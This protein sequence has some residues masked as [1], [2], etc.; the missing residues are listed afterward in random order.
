MATY[1]LTWNPTRWE[2]DYLA[3]SAARVQLGEK[4]DDSWSTGS[5]QI[6]PGDRLFLLR[7]RVDPRGIMAAAAATSIA[8]VG[9]HYDAVRAAAG[10]TRTYVDLTWDVLLLPAEGRLLPRPRLDQSDLRGAHW[11]T[12][13]SGILIPEDVAVSLEVA[14]TQHLNDIGYWKRSGSAASG[15]G[16]R[17]A[18]EDEGEAEGVGNHIRFEQFLPFC[19]EGNRH[20]QQAIHD[21]YGNS[22]LR[23]L[24]GGKTMTVNTA[25]AP[26]RI[27]RISNRNHESDERIWQIDPRAEKK[28]RRLLPT[29]FNG[30]RMVVPENEDPVF[31][32]AVVTVLADF[33]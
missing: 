15:S 10:E 19:G 3:E 18:G 7:Q 31:T 29:A 2:W 20:L 4:V 30:D 8:K 11:S 33:L 12:Q 26:G 23:L 32:D 22:R 5:A 28:L 1:L 6:R 14:W 25:D 16:P 13:K 21:R 9:P 17:E 27:M 24:Y